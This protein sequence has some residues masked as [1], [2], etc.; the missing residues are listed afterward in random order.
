VS[1][2]YNSERGLL[3]IEIPD[4]LKFVKEADSHITVRNQLG[5]I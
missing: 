5:Q 4:F 1:L 3:R 2:K